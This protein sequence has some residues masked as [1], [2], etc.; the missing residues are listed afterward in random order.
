MSLLWGCVPYLIGLVT[1]NVI[2]MKSVVQAVFSEDMS[3]YRTNLTVGIT[4]E[5]FSCT[6]HE[7]MK[8]MQGKT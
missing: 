2:N 8:A 1:F 3:Y 4:F 6:K 7:D 5:E